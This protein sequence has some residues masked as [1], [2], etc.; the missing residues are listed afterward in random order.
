MSCGF[1]KFYLLLLFSIKLRINKKKTERLIKTPVI[2]YF[3][4]LY[5][6]IKVFVPAGISKLLNL[7][8]KGWEYMYLSF[9]IRI[10]FLSYCSENM[11]VSPL[12]KF[13]KFP[14]YFVSEFLFKFISISLLKRYA[15]L[16]VFS[17]TN[18]P[19]SL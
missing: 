11:R 10:Q 4:V 14:E 3:C 18:T 6:K 2:T 16:L 17:T 9:K 7:L 8:L 13:F 12:L 1:I 19:K 5:S 15:W